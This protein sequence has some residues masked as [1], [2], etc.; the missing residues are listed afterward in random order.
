MAFTTSEWIKTQFDNFSKRIAQVFAKKTEVPEKTSDITNDSGFI[1]N[2]VDNL[3][4]YYT[5]TEVNGIVAEIG[6]KSL[7]FDTKSDLDTWM[8]DTNNTN[9]LEVGQN[10]YIKETDTP[11][12]WWDGTSLQPLETEKVNLDGYV[13][14]E[15][16]SSDLSGYV[17][18][19]DAETENIDFSGYFA[20]E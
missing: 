1:T 18:K 16:L 10:I 11:D 8:E 4:N 20:S 17:S 5:K 15:Q 7:V 6:A 12:Y 3:T 9:S 13:T 19:D 2:S 14:S